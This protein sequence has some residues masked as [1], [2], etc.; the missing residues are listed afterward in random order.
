MASVYRL[1]PGQ[2]VHVE[3]SNT[4]EVLTLL[5]PLSFTLFDHYRVL[6]PQ[7]Q[8]CIVV[9]SDYY[10][11]IHNP[12][13][14]SGADGVAA[15]TASHESPLDSMVHAS[16][17]CGY[18]LVST[19]PT[20]LKCPS[21][22]T[23]HVGLT[24]YRFT[25]SP[26]PLFPGEV[27]EDPQPIPLLDARTAFLL[28]VVQP[29]SYTDAASGQTSQREVGEKY[30]FKGPGRYR[31][32]VEERVV[33]A[34]GALVVK[35]NEVVFLSARQ[36]HADETGTTRVAG[37]VWSVRAE[38]IYFPHPLATVVSVET[39]TVLSPDVA[40]LVQAKTNHFDALFQ[41]ERKLGD[42][43]LVTENETSIFVPSKEVNKVKTVDRIALGPRQYCLVRHPYHDGENRWG[44]VEMRQG[45]SSF[46][47]HPGEEIMGRP[48]RNAFVLSECEALL[49]EARNTF[50]DED[51]VTR[52]VA[53]RWLVRGPR[54]YIPPLSVRVLEQRCPLPLDVNSGVYVRNISTGAIRSVYGKPFLL[55]EDE[56]LW[57]K[58]VSTTVRT[59]IGASRLSVRKDSVV[60]SP[61]RPNARALGR[62][63]DTDSGNGADTTDS[64][65]SEDETDG[66]ASAEDDDYDDKV[67]N[68][69][70]SA[71]DLAKYSVVS[72]KVDQNMLVR[73][74]DVS[75]GT[76]RVEAGPTVVVLG[77][78][79]QFMPL[80]LS[81]G[82]PKR[83]NQILSLGLFLGPDYMADVIEVE[84]LDHA[85]LSLHLAYNWEFD[86]NDKAHIK[87]VAFT[88]PDFVGEACK[89]LAS[90]VRAAIAGV[91][92]ELFHCLS[93]SVIRQAIFS[94]AADGSEEVQGDSLYFR[95]N[96]LRIT[97][98]DVQSVEPVDVKTRLALTKSEQLA[99][100]IIT[101]AQESEATHRATLLEQEAKGTLELQEM[102]DKAMAEVDRM[103]LLM[104]MVHNAAIEQT[105][106]SMAQAVAEKEARLVEAQAELD[107]T[108]KRCASHDAGA[109]AELA[110]LRKR[111]ELEL[112]HRKVMNDL[113]VQRST[114]LGSVEAKK[115]EQIMSALGKETVVALAQAGPELQAKLLG[116]LGLQGFLVTDGSSPVNLFNLSENLAARQRI[117]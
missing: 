75:T 90:R 11:A 64:N 69:H 29:Y 117:M 68:A 9:P 22:A 71:A 39:E 81:G 55:S 21:E 111:M 102:N 105:S 47:P 52:A 104:V 66:S 95:V 80:Y 88:L 99:V 56:A 106:A 103:E 96:G 107:A 50:T 85:R 18:R 1:L 12:V 38:G 72:A 25:Q 116:A 6:H 33:T 74:Y 114:A 40:L 60:D 94:S 84:T 59:L 62:W 58:P 87:Q 93:S 5:G 36:S 54:C 112:S 23:C 76:I 57:E 8:P 19:D 27:A 82:R 78:H 30:L 14:R 31:P 98:V 24:E 10:V 37:E 77:P 32:R 70:L 20:L 92:F 79:E 35:S 83:P 65:C 4:C 61:C 67:R 115:Y 7:P 63:G 100:E 73:V 17:P 89:T 43:W 51:G 41:K 13:R 48:V 110:V 46:F 42:T 26:F 108:P 53:T 45:V 15:T 2:Y 3:D 86:T 101:K 49:V 91:T 109:D 16:C 28:E 113:A 34:V 44:A 97:N